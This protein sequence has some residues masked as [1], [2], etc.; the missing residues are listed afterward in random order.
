MFSD[1]LILGGAVWSCELDSMILATWDIL[2]L[3]ITNVLH[4]N[5]VI[6]MNY[7]VFSSHST[8]CYDRKTVGILNVYHFLAVP[9]VTLASYT[10]AHL[11]KQKGTDK[12]VLAS[13]RECGKHKKHSHS[14]IFI[15]VNFHLL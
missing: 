1:S 9:E 14:T 6:F 5:K 15:S 11:L 3:F 8:K 7:I 10:V 12:L 2:M 4:K 13:L